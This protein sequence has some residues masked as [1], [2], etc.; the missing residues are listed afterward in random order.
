MHLSSFID[1]FIKELL[2]SLIS[3]FRSLETIRSAIVLAF[4]CSVLILI[5]MLLL[6]LMIIF[7]SNVV[8]L[9][10]LGVGILLKL[11]KL[12]ISVG[13]V[14]HALHVSLII[15]NLIIIDHIITIVIIFYAGRL[16]LHLPV[17]VGHMRL[18]LQILV[19]SSHFTT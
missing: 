10:L 6:L 14:I 9:L 1:L 5:V 16:H 7:L 19:E 13:V 18:S 15:L 12:F 2:M 8:L 17:N 3:I 11:R 4:F